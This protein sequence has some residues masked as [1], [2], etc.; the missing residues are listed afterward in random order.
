MDFHGSAEKQSMFYTP[1]RLMCI[2][3][4][5]LPIKLSGWLLRIFRVCQHVENFYSAA[6]AAFEDKSLVYGAFE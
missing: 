4:F 5:S 1:E 6:L 3:T 2:R